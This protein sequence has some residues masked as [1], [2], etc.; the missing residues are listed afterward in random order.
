MHGMRLIAGSGRSGTTWILDSLATANGLRP[1]FE[2]LHPNVSDVGNKYAHRALVAGSDHPELERFLVDVCAGRTAAMWT[3]YRRQRTWLLPPPDRLSSRHDVG[4]VYRHW[5]K[6]LR[7]LPE[8]IAASRRHIPIVK[9]VRANLMLDWLVRSQSARVVMVIRHP[10]AVIESELRGSWNANFA[11][12]RFRSDSVLHEVTQGRYVDFL[13][14]RMTRVEALAVRWVVENQW[15][16]ERAKSCGH[17]VV[18]YEHLRASPERTWQTVTNA[19][20]L[21]RVPGADLLARPSQQS[22]TGK[23]GEVILDRRTRWQQS[24]SRDQLAEIQGVLDRAQ[25][26]MYSMDDAEPHCPEEPA[27]INQGAGG[28]Q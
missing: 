25:C 14:R 23:G 13:N 19:L 18:H 9:C 26:G 27:S 6:L 21:D 1:V 20:G 28:R 2:P 5:S 10:A 17:A 24:L 12:E 11:L 22:S 3:K 16:S 15:V 4:R 7:D 8:L